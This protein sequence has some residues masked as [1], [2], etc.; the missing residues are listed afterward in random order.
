[1]KPDEKKIWFP[2]KRYG[3]GWGLPCRWQG[4][5]FLLCWLAALVSGAV[6]I[7]P[8]QHVAA[9]IIFE[10]SMILVLLIVC[11]LKGEKPGWRWGGK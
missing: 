3:W 8:D 1:M 4:W 11:W 6:G 2:A 7:R 10:V 9:F 5:V